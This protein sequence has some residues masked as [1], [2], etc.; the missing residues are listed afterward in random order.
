[1]QLVPMVQYSCRKCG[2]ALSIGDKACMRCGAP[3][4]PAPHEARAFCVKCGMPFEGVGGFCMSCGTPRDEVQAMRQV[5]SQ[6]AIPSSTPHSSVVMENQPAR[7]IV[8]PPQKQSLFSR[9]F[10]KKNKQPADPEPVAQMQA[11]QPMSSPQMPV[12]YQPFGA[13]QEDPTIVFNDEGG[14]MDDLTTVLAADSAVFVVRNSTGERI[15]IAC[16]AVLGKGSA[17]THRIANNPAISRQHVCV[18]CLDGEYFLEDLNS[19]NKTKVGGS[20]LVPGM[21]V[22]ICS[23]QVFELA[24]ESFAFY[25]EL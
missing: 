21:P 23:G 25:V 2:G 7:Q 4:E 13:D 15:E 1:M 3:A 5:A 12:V 18:T 19:T 22:R 6:S 8:M 20:E 14:S 24:D 10:G 17:A 16:P 9:L 11:K